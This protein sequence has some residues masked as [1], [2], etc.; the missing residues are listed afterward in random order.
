MLAKGVP[1]IEFFYMTIG[2]EYQRGQ[3]KPVK[4]R[5]HGIHSAQLKGDGVPGRSPDQS[6]YQIEE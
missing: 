6:G 5:D 4:D 1:H 2:L 3:E